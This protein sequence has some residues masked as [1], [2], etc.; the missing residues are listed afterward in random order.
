MAH[1][2]LSPVEAYFQYQYQTPTSRHGFQGIV[3]AEIRNRVVYGYDLTAKEDDEDS[4]SSDYRRFTYNLFLGMRYNIPG[5][6]GYFSRFAFGVRLYHGNC[7][8]GHFRSIDNFSQVGV[9]FVFQ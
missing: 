4:G 9:A 2:R 1:A 7:P 6:D 5:Y 3:S 8:F